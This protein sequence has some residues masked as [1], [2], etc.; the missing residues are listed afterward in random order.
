MRCS[1]V[2]GIVCASIAMLLSCAPSADDEL[3]VS[4]WSC[5]SSGETFGTAAVGE[6]GDG[7]EVSD[8]AKCSWFDV[9]SSDA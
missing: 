6:V 8:V 5:W 2:V 3:L 9:S 7:T 1:G 4:V